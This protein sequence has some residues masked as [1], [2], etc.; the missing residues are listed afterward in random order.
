MLC[1]GLNSNNSSFDNL[2]LKISIYRWNEDKR[3][4]Q[5]LIEDLKESIQ[6][7]LNQCLDPK[8]TKTQFSKYYEKLTKL[9]RE[10]YQLK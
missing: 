8:S 7:V 3:Y 5:F 2:I 4:H 10:Q 9:R 1:N 6:I